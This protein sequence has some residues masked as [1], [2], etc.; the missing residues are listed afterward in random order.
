MN[1]HTARGFP[2]TSIDSNS[3]NLIFLQ[4]MPRTSPKKAVILKKEFGFHRG[5]GRIKKACKYIFFSYTS[6]VIQMNE[7]PKSVSALRSLF[8]LSRFF[9]FYLVFCIDKVII[10]GTSKF[11][12]KR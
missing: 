9:V 4:V 12:I 7:D 3:K 8:F 6:V 2:Y 11:F 10:I 1:N 5:K